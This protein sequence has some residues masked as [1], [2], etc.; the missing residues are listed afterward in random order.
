MGNFPVAEICLP[1]PGDP[2]FSSACSI[3]T[4]AP[5]DTFLK[6]LASPKTFPITLTALAGR[7]SFPRLMGVGPKKMQKALPV[8]Q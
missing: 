8:G 4:L 1:N 7:T 2:Y 3:F 6:T 5:E